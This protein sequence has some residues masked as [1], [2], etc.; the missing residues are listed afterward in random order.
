MALLALALGCDWS[1]KGGAAGSG[2]LCPSVCYL[3]EQDI[4]KVL[5]AT[6]FWLVVSSYLRFGYMEP[7]ILEAVPIRNIPGAP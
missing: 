1:Q 3:G 7:C 2:M 6:F 5:A 4:F